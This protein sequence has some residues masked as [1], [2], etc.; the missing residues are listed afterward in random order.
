[1]KLKYLDEI[2]ARREAIA[3]MYSELAGIVGLPIYQPGR[4]WQDYVIRVRDPEKLAY[5]LKEKGIQT[6]GVGMTPPHRALN[7]RVHLPAVDRLFKEMLRLPLNETLSDAQVRYVIKC[8][9]NFYEV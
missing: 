9:K 4:V 1:M 5:F 2:L 3:Y 8:V 6:L 7:I